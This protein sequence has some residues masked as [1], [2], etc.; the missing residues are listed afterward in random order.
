MSFSS[1]LRKELN[2]LTTGSSRRIY[3][4]KCFLTGG[5]LSDPAKSYHMSFTLPDSKAEKLIK[6][7]SEFDLSPKTLVKNG[8]TVVYLKEAEEISDVL[9]IMRASKTLLAFENQRIEKDVRNTLNRQVNCE[10]ANLNKTVTAAQHQIDAIDFIAS[11]VGLEHLSKP[12]QDVARLRQVH[13][14]ASLAEIGEMLTPPIGKSGVNHR[15]RKI[16]E[17]ADDMKRFK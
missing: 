5:T 17:I 16:C 2:S 3:V 8:Q 11:E 6:I 4:R 13:D 15:L 14:T 1:E 9:K 7:L 12:L 10:A